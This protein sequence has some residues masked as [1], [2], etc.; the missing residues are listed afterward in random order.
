MRFSI[1]ALATIS[2]ASLCL[3]DFSPAGCKARTEVRDALRDELK[4]THL[5]QLKFTDK[6][7]RRHEVPTKTIPAF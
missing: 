4:Q 1:G 2:F 7:A 3:A 6:A 5:D